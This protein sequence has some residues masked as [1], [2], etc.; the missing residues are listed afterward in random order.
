M[1][2]QKRQVEQVAWTHKIVSKQFEAYIATRSE[3]VIAASPAI[4]WTMGHRFDKVR[5][6]CSQRGYE[7][8]DLR[9]AKR[10]RS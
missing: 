7:L 2:I 10:K 5:E 1:P 8:F 9:P 6:I 4:H 3:K